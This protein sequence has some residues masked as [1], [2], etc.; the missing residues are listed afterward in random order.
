MWKRTFQTA[1][2]CSMSIYLHVCM[3]TTY[4]LSVHKVLILVSL[5]VGARIGVKPWSS[6]RMSALNCLVVLTFYSLQCWRQCLSENCFRNSWRSFNQSTYWLCPYCGWVYVDCLT[7]VTEGEAGLVC[8]KLASG[9][10]SLRL[11][12]GSSC[13]HLLCAGVTEHTFTPSFL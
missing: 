2:Y 1:F 12:F 6:T 9:F 5:H 10:S 7:K 3:C 11:N 8:P 13:L 4:V